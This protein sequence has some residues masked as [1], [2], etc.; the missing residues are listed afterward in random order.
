[1]EPAHSI[2][3]SA[4]VKSSPQL[5]RNG[6]KRAKVCKFSFSRAFFAAF[7]VNRFERLLSA[8]TLK[9]PMAKKRCQID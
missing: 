6:R 2:L 4:L 9:L 3:R 7:A 1:M 8:E 5:N